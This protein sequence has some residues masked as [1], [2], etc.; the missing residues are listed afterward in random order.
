M[1]ATKQGLHQLFWIYSM[2]YYVNVMA[3]FYILEY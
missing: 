1:E 2:E 3:V